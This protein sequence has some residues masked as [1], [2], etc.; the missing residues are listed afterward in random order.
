MSA[1]LVLTG[2]DAGYGSARVL[3]EVTLQVR[4]G[5]IT[6]LTGPNGAGKSTLVRSVLGAADLH[7]GSIAIDGQD[8][9]PLT[10]EE[11][12]RELVGWVPEGRALFP[13]ATVRDNLRVAAR[14]WGLRGAAIGRRVDAIADRFPVVAEKMSSPV[15]TLSGG[16]Q[17]IVAVAR[18]FLGAPRVLLL[19]EPST[20]L[21]PVAWLAVLDTCLDAAS[22]GPAVLVVEQRLLDALDAVDRLAVLVRGRVV[23]EGSAA[24]A[25]LTE[26]ALA[27]YFSR[28]SA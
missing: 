21:S 9:A 18:A 27:D 1:G 15:S 24:D 10:R 8:L 6:L 26:R 19:D 25:S 11:R 22:E 20:G 14:A 3:H 28:D 5:T 16:Q 7:A 2:V 12:L 23:R 17:Q 13:G 4:P